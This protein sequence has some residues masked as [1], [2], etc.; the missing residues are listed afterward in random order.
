MRSSAQLIAHLDEIYS[1][2]RTA[3]LNTRY[4]GELLSNYQQRNT[5]LEIA[6]ALG[7]TGSGVSGLALWNQPYGKAIWGAITAISSLLAVAKPILQMNKKIERY[8]KLFTGHLDNFLAIKSLVTKIRRHQKLSKDMIQEFEVA[9]QRFIDLSR[10][11]DP[12]PNT[13]LQKTCE[14]AVLVQVPDKMLWFPEAEA[15]TKNPGPKRRRARKRVK[16]PNPEKV[17]SLQVAA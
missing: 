4:Y 10:G 8:S 1:M 6:I 17:R 7:A 14:A 12:R 9:E 15:N 16:Q 2:Y 13:K 3:A 5:I 11:D